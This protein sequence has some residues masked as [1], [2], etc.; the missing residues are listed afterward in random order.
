[1]SVFNNYQVSGI[2]SVTVGGTGTTPKYFQRPTGNF[3]SGTTIGPSA[4]SGAGQLNA[5]GFNVLNG[6]K[7]TVTAAG[8]FE[9]GSCGACPNVTIDMVANTG[10]VAAPIW[11]AIASTGAVTTQP[12][13]GVFY[14]WYLEA[15]ILGT[16]ASGIIQGQFSAVVDNVLQNS[17]PKVLL[18]NLSGLNFATDP[19][20]G[21]AVRVT[22]SVSDSGNSANMYQFQLASI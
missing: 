2:Q 11:T 16:T 15:Q 4:S 9:V 17:T 12:L 3:T 8:D 5:Q 21:L 6:Q 7:I 19:V 22:F 20:F 1:M 13:T 18:A 10:T 14:P